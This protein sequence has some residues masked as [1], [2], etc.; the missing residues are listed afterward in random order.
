MIMLLS[1]GGILQRGRKKQGDEK[2]EK[3][4]QLKLLSVLTP[5]RD[6]LHVG[7][8]SVFCFFVKHKEVTGMSVSACVC[9]SPY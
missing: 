1:Y 9:A 7:G 5:D 8:C 3:L 4:N 2:E 6:V